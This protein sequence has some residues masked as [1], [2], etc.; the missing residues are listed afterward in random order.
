MLRILLKLSTVFA[1]S[2]TLSWYLYRLHGIPL[3]GPPGETVWYFAYG[4]NMHDSAF[5][6]WRGMRPLVHCARQ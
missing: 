2:W 6:A 4:A 5:R 3:V 1:R